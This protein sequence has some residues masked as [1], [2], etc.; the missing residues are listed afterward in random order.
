M[1]EHTPEDASLPPRLPWHHRAPVLTMALNVALILTIFLT[2]ERWAAWQIGERLPFEKIMHNGVLPSPRL[3]GRAIVSME[4]NFALWRVGPE[5][6]TGGFVGTCVCECSLLRAEPEELLVFVEPVEADQIDGEVMSRAKTRGFTV[7]D[8]PAL[9]IV[10]LQRFEVRS[11]LAGV[12]G[13][14]TWAFDLSPDGKSVAVACGDHAIRIVDV[15]SM[16][17]Q[18]EFTGHAADVTCVDWSSATNSIVTAD[19]AGTVCVW[20][21][22]TGQRSMKIYAHEGGT[23]LAMFAAHGKQLLT[24][25]ATEDE[26]CIWHSGTGELVHR[27]MDTRLVLCRPE[28]EFVVCQPCDGNAFL[29]LDALTGARLVELAGHT[30]P[31]SLILLSSKELLT[32]STYD[33]TS[34]LWNTQ[35]GSCVGVFTGG[36]GMIEES[37][38]RMFTWQGDGVLYVW[39]SRSHELLA[40]STGVYDFLGYLG[41]WEAVVCGPS[42]EPRVFRRIRPEQWWGVF[43]LPHLYLIVALAVGVVLSGWRDLRRIRRMNANGPTG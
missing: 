1:S 25:S 18:C 35:T 16:A 8:K 17:V 9:M 29:V 24:T 38:S 20:N 12:P 43:W 41:N 42:R 2:R 15:E 4:E 19:E 5:G 33:V 40:T 7:I 13:G 36:H 6:T 21:P 14:V 26:S 32:H 22:R 30:S 34:R 39:D 10:D 27:M 3:D 11:M 23:W 28:G 37:I 31:N